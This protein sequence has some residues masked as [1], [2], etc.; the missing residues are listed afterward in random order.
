[1]K[2]Q[3]KVTVRKTLIKTLDNEK[4][5]VVDHEIVG[6]LTT[7]ECRDYVNANLENHTFILKENITDTFNVDTIALTQLKESN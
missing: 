1:M 5:V 3:T 7:V 6:K 2:N 4:N